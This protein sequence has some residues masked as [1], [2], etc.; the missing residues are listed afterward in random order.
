MVYQGMALSM[1]SDIRW[2]SQDITLAYKGD[3]CRKAQS[4]RETKD[5]NVGSKET[6]KEELRIGKKTDVV[7][8][9]PWGGEA[10]MEMD[11]FLWV[12]SMF[13]LLV[14]L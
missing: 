12:M 3:H 9:D 8:L 14:F 4:G 5:L 11:R 10:G 7:I 1:A 13:S 6:L 2:G